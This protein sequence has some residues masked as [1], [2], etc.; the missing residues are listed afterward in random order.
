MTT[1]ISLRFIHK[2]LVPLLIVFLFH[3][4]KIKAQGSNDSLKMNTIKDYIDHLFADDEVLDITL[5][6]KMRELLNDRGD[7]PKYHSCFLMINGPSIYDSVN[8][9]IKT[10]GHF[11]KLKENC[12]YPPLLLDFTKSDIESSN[13]FFG[14]AKL[15]LVTPCRDDKY[16]IREFLVYKLYNLISNF[17]FNA[18]LVRVTFNEQEK[19]KNT[20]PLY[21][22]ILEDEEKLARRNQSVIVDRELV[23]PEFANKDIFLKMSVFQYMIGNTDWSVQYLQNI[24]LLLTDTS[25]IPVTVPYDFDHAGIVNASYAR[26]AEE[27]KLYSIRQRRYRGYCMPDTGEFKNTFHLFNQLKPGFYNLYSQNSMLDE[28]YK[29]STIN[30]LDDFFETINN[31]EESQSEFTYPCDKYGTGNVVI[32]G[33]KK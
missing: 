29:K 25:K 21:G 18:R 6:G 5:S 16:I 20:D 10:R 2:I 9:Q 24:K 15:K 19:N 7:D 13:P 27:L 17:S 12:S 28:K 14:Q 31:P 3:F 32:Q 11:R 23:R 1:T 8:L 22:I 4:Q 26:P 30:F 33:L